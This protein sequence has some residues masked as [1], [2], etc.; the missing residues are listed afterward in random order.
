MPQSPSITVDLQDE[1]ASLDR[2]LASGDYASPSEV[3]RAGLRAL[4]CE[5]TAFD[6]TARERI[7]E[8]FDD[9]RP[10]IPAEEVFRELRELHAK[11]WGKMP[12]AL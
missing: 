7:R 11:R 12:D 3:L 8:G 5:Q 1:Q 4:D 10:D 9:P 2:H 6:E